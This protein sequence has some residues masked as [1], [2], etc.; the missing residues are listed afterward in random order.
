MTQEQN[1][2]ID[3]AVVQI[4]LSE[5]CGWR[6]MSQLAEEAGI[7]RQLLTYHAKRRASLLMD[8]QPSLSWWLNRTLLKI[9]KGASQKASH[10]DSSRNNMNL[11]QQDD[12]TPKEVKGQ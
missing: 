4:V 11:N 10:P 8:H 7:S 9:I 5:V 2:L 3:E 6:T 1:N 12:N